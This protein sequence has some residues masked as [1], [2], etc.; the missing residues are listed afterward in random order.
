[1]SCQSVLQI[2]PPTQ[3]E[4]FSDWHQVQAEGTLVRCLHWVLCSPH[5]PTTLV[6]P[7][8]PIRPA[9]FYQKGLALPGA[10]C[11]LKF[12]CHTGQSQSGAGILL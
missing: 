3:R 1:M 9:L 10:K 12:G 2:P 11:C 6:S 4:V 8:L 7:I 5:Q